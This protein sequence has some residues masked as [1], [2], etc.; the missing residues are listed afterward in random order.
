MTKHCITRMDGP[1]QRFFTGRFANT[2]RYATVQLL[3]SPKTT[4][5]HDKAQAYDD[6][7]VA[8]LVCDYLNIVTSAAIGLKPW[9]IMPLPEGRR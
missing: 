5:R 4:G 6:Q 3:P 2:C 8:R 1:R 7:H 9:A